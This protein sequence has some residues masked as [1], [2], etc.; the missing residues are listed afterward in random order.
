MTYRVA[1]TEMSHGSCVPQRLKAGYWDMLTV[2]LSPSLKASE[3][4]KP[5]A[6]LSV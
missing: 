4:E 6:K 2:E 3:L 5:R 1:A